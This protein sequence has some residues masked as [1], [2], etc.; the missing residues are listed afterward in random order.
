MGWLDGLVAPIYWSV[1]TEVTNENYRLVART[2]PL[3][4]K[5]VKSIEQQF[6]LRVEDIPIGT[7]FKIEIE[8]FSKEQ[9]AS[10]ELLLLR[11]V[12]PS[13]SYLTRELKELNIYRSVKGIQLGA[14][15][16][17]IKKI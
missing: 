12:K 17:G 15:F 2:K 1:S 6:K 7:I 5:L 4:S 14:V 10:I 3:S 8:Y 9:L 13:F 16:E 11:K